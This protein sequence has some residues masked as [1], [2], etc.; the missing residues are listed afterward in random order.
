ML[1]I[2][3]L[4]VL[5]II[6]QADN[7]DN[8]SFAINTSQ[9]AYYYTNQKHTNTL[10]FNITDLQVINNRAYYIVSSNSSF[11]TNYPLNFNY[12]YENLSLRQTTYINLTIHTKLLHT[13]YFI[14]KLL[15]LSLQTIEIR[16]LTIPQLNVSNK[17]ISLLFGPINIQS[18]LSNLAFSS[19]FF[20]TINILHGIFLRESIFCLINQLSNTTFTIQQQLSSQY[21]NSSTVYTIQLPF[22][23]PQTINYTINS[24]HANYQLVNT[25]NQMQFTLNS[26]EQN[27]ISLIHSTPSFEFFSLVAISVFLVLKKRR[28]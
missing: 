13:Y 19:D 5:S 27:V 9:T 26:S 15:G 12:T 10:L 7:A 11:S 17:N 2:F 4:V 8:T 21:M 14:D 18:V 25:T 1:C 24:L 3:F 22:L 28:V 16:S 6:V 23:L 20:Q